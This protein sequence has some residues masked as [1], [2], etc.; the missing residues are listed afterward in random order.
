M[1][2]MAYAAVRLRPSAGGA[3]LLG[4]VVGALLVVLFAGVRMAM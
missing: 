3:L 1:L 2:G 4:F